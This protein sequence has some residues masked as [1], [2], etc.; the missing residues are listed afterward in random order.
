MS[1]LATVASLLLAGPEAGQ[2]IHSNVAATLVE[3]WT[4]VYDTAEQTVYGGRSD[5][6]LTSSDDRRVRTLVAPVALP[7]LGDR[8]LYLEEFLHDDPENPRRLVLLKLDVEPSAR[9]TVRV[10]QFTFRDPARWRKLY[11]SP[12]E[13]RSLTREDLEAIAGCD[14]LLVREGD[15]FRGGTSGR[16]CIDDAKDPERYVSYQVVIGKSLYWFHKRLMT[17]DDE[18]I[19]EAVAFDWFELHE[20]RLFTCR[21]RWSPPQA[22]ERMPVPKPLTSLD[23]HDQGGKVRFTTPDGRVYEIALHSRDWPFD[24]NRDALIL[25][26]QEAGAV[27]PLASSW[28]GLGDRQIEVDLGWMNVACGPVAAARDDVRS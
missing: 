14:L 23:V 26:L 3:R 13:I 1:L 11:R 7:W 10:R 8:V 17:L 20:A 2:S 16:G 18:L 24:S 6:E 19:E 25:I 27:A 5:S 22:G 12:V 28:T 4:G 15:Q 9:Q 21:V